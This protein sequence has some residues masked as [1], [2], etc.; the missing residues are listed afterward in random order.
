[1]AVIVIGTD[2][3]LGTHFG[4]SPGAVHQSLGSPQRQ[5]NR[6]PDSGLT[7]M[8]LDRGAMLSYDED[9]HLDFI[10]L[11]PPANPQWQA[12]E[13]LGRPFAEVAD[14]LRTAGLEGQPYDSGIDYAQI[15][16]RLYTSHPSEPDAPVDSVGLYQTGE[17]FA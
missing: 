6:T 14:D 10:E 7:E 16:M 5:F 8:Y 13:L 1:M 2:S 15:G 4:D 17:S 3:I 11:V 12:I 9:A